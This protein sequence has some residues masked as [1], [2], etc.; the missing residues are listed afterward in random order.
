MSFCHSLLALPTSNPHGASDGFLQHK[1]KP[2]QVFL[3]VQWLPVIL[4][5]KDKLFKILCDLEANLFPNLC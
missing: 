3:H 5:I 2:E 4:R 1:C